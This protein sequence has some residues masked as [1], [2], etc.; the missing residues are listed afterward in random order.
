MARTQAADFGRR[1]EEIIDR[2][3]KLFAQRG[4]LGTSIAELAVACDVSKSLIYHYFGSKEDLLY[5]AMASHVDAL[6]ATAEQALAAGPADEQFRR[7][8]KGFMALYVDAAAR[9]QV[10][11]NDPGYLPGERRDSIFARQRNLIRIVEGMLAEAH[12]AL[13]RR[14]GLLRTRTMLFFGMINWTHTWFNPSGPIS[15]DQ[16]ADM[17]CDMILAAVAAQEPAG[18]PV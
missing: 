13:L 17:A 14:K 7:L 3:A 12:P 4:F 5:E 15:P 1:R 9:H 18:E 16:V 2:A 8:A 6:T 11:L 10:L